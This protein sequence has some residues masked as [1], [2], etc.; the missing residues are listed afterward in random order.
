[1]T[2]DRRRADDR[3]GRRHRS[4]TP[5][6]DRALRWQKVKGNPF[7]RGQTAPVHRRRSPPTGRCPGEELLSAWK[8]SLRG[9]RTAGVVAVD[10][11]AL[12]DLVG[13]TGPR[14]G[15]EATARSTDAN[16]VAEAG[17]RATT[18]YPDNEARKDGSTAPSSRS[19]PT[20][21]SAA[22]SCVDKTG[23]LGEAARG[24]HFALYFRDP[25]AAGGVRRHRPRR[26][27]SD[28]RRTTTSAS[29]PRTPTRSKADYWQRAA[30]APTCTL[31]P[32]GTATVPARRSTVHNDSPPYAPAG[33]DPRNGLLHPLERPERSA[34]S[35]PT[36]SSV[37]QRDGRRRAVGSRAS[38]TSTA[39]PSCARRSQLRP[40]GPRRRSPS[41]TTSRAAATRDGD[42]DLTY[43]LASTR[44][45]WS[46]RQARPVTVQL[47]DGL[48]RRRPSPRAGPHRRRR[49][50]DVP[51]PTVTR[52]QSASLVEITLHHALDSAPWIAFS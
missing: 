21:C 46:T 22:A 20:G 32:D 12:A 27:L 16:L 13:V 23:S 29:S 11:V 49:V 4:T 48:R 26:R 39:G 41:S 50:V 51:G 36:A 44:R 37:D 19:S 17:R 28:T 18:H 31:A 42:G 45:A 33:P 24:R 10:V 7:H 6:S 52:A 40:A 1:M 47:P 2:S 5:S 43:R 9:R 8:R 38:A 25:D 14:G 34:S 35:C 15:P 3:R 30:V